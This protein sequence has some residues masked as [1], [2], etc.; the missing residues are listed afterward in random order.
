[1]RGLHRPLWQTNTRT[2]TTWE[3]YPMEPRG[4]KHSA[5]SMTTGDLIRRM[6][7]AYAR[8]DQSGFKAAVLDLITEERRKNHNVYARELERIISNAEPASPPAQVESLT[9]LGVRDGD[10][11]RD[12]DRDAVLVDVIDPQRRLDDLILSSDVRRVLDR[13]VEEN[14]RGELIRSHG[15]HPIRKILFCGP[16]GC[17]K[18]VA[19]EAVAAALYLPLVVVRFDAVVS[20]YLCETAAK[21]RKVF[22]FV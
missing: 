21:L 11:P 15:L 12:K 8:G 16:P 2:F 6:V 14:R 13:I 20:S 5:T 22:E 18:T 9:L 1:M 7:I 19:G 10:L 3:G 17:G 4:A